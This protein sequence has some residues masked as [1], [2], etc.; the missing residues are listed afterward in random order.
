MRRN[1]AT[2][3]ELQRAVD[4]YEKYRSQTKA[5][6]A[7]GISRNT[8]RDWLRR[9]KTDGI[10]AGGKVEVDLQAER[11]VEYQD[12]IR[13]LQLQLATIR[14]DNI[15]ARIV[16]E[17]ILK[18]S[19]V[20]LSPPSFLIKPRRSGNAGIPVTM[21]GDWHWGE[22]VDPDQVNGVNEYSLKIARDRARRLVE[23]IVRLAKA[24]M[25]GTDYPGIVVCLCGDL[26]SGDIHD[27]LSETNELPTMP[28]MLD[29]YG[30]LI[31]AIS[32]LADEFGK[33]FIPVVAGN[34]ARNTTRP[35]FKNRNYSNF[36]WLLGCLLEK[37]FQNDKRIHVQVA[38]G[39]DVHFEVQGQRFCLT[40]G[41]NLGTRGGD[42]II[43]AV[44]PI[45]RGDVKT[46]AQAEAI[47]K[48][49]DTLLIGHWHQYM[50]LD[51]VVVNGSLIG[52]NEYAH[53]KLRARF[54][55]PRQSLFFVHQEHGIICHWPVYVDEPQK[56]S[57]TPSEWV[58]W[59]A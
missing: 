59:E 13:E 51:N 30:V 44:G 57:A 49:Y 11:E 56:S 32:T 43:G 21:W 24:H 3:A 47:G 27:E 46:R 26:V 53:L 8:I 6:Q 31:W 15:T 52:F 25:V 54:E 23:G 55:P 7:M 19:D 29:L 1:P 58:G 39:A 42:G 22:V 28:V 38:K 10:V 14:R 34:H 40:H 16:R 4:L 12:Q 18:L 36:D 2:P 20:E 5:A 41:D 48:R 9:A 45:I 35:R 50:P 37:H 17:T 33:V